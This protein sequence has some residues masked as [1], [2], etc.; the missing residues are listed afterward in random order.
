VARTLTYAAV[1]LAIAAIQTARQGTRKT[2]QRQQTS[3]L[4]SGAIGIIGLAA[5]KRLTRRAPRVTG[6][7]SKGYRRLDDAGARDNGVARAP[8]DVIAQQP[9]T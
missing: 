1:P 3:W 4:V 6:G 2:R 8:G 5:F 9:A 7:V